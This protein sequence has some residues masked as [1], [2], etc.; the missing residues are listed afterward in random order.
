M[1]RVRRLEVN[2]Q[3]APCPN[4]A[5]ARRAFDRDAWPADADQDGVRGL[6]PRHVHRARDEED[7]ILGRGVGGGEQIPD[8]RGIA[9]RGASFRRQ[10]DGLG[11]EADDSRLRAEIRASAQGEAGQVERIDPDI[12]GGVEA[13]QDRVTHCDPVTRLR[14]EDSHLRPRSVGRPDDPRVGETI[15]SP[16]GYKQEERGDQE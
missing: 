2:P 16:A 7:R 13:H 14:L 9:W 10:P 3:V 4:L 5:A 1:E 8:D 6:V 15:V 12:V 11:L